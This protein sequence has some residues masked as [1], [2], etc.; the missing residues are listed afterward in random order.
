[1]RILGQLQ[2]TLV[3]PTRI[4]LLGLNQIAPSLVTWLFCRLTKVHI[5]PTLSFPLTRYSFSK[6]QPSIR[7]RSSLFHIKEWLN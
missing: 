6:S 2:P 1:M 4:T 5:Q 7:V 3:F